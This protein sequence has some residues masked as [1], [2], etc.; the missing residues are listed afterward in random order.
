MI[1]LEIKSPEQHSFF[2][3]RGG[4][5]SATIERLILLQ[6]ILV[7]QPDVVEAGSTAV[8]FRQPLGGILSKCIGDNG[9]RMGAIVGRSL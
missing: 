5:I 7:G 8:R 6:I 2:T 4:I 9:A 3:S 1:V